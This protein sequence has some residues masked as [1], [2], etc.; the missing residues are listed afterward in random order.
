M[1][2]IVITKAI[3]KLKTA[4]ALNWDGAFVGSKICLNLTFIMKRTMVLITSLIIHLTLKEYT[5]QIS[6]KVRCAF[7][8]QIYSQSNTFVAQKNP[9]IDE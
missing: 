7:L 2:K 4:F 5:Y 8:M 3:K 6:V 9:T 1:T